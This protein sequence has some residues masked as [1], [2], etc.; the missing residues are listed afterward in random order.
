MQGHTAVSGYFARKAWPTRIVGALLLILVSP[1]IFLLVLLVRFTSSGPGLY[2]QV[3]SGRHGKEFDMYKIRTMYDGAESV[4]G[5]VWCRP[6]DSR[7]TP[8]GRALR[9]LHLD[10]LP[11]LI[12][13]ARGEMDLIGPRPERPMFVSRLAGSIPNYHARLLVLPGVTG[14][15]QVNLP[16]DETFDCVRRKLVLD[17]L[18]IR[19]ASAFLDVRILLCTFLRMLG[20]RHGRAVR[21]LG[22]E[23]DIHLTPSPAHRA[24]GSPVHWAQDIAFSSS[25]E[26]SPHVHANGVAVVSIGAND[27]GHP[28]SSIALSEADD[29]LVFPLRLPR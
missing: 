9:L 7:I 16:P 20:I 17:C 4:T 1:L 14:L 2:R 12:N 8:L 21:W 11:Q 25:L 27:N 5:P 26:G 23:R 19:D 18:Y 6:G 28:I 15:A 24:G 13:V 3:R 29:E 10:E 22:L